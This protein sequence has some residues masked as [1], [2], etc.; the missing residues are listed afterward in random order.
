MGQ[1]I[2]LRLLTC[3]KFCS[4]SRATPSTVKMDGPGTAVL[5]FPKTQRS[6]YS[7]GLSTDPLGSH[8]V[9]VHLTAGKGAWRQLWAYGRP[10]LVGERLCCVLGGEG[11]GEQW[12]GRDGERETDG[13]CVCT[14]GNS[15]G[16][17]SPCT[18][19]PLH[20]G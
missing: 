14:S 11:E 15:V 3:G 18:Q 13:E 19:F 8:L 1:S 6:C 12:Q 7:Q 20:K 4:D 5:K 17:Q 10:G 16:K 2:L 9:T